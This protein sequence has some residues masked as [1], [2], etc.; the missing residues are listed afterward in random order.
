[1][2][3]TNSDIQILRLNKELRKI[4]SKTIPE[5][6][7]RT[8]NNMAF[9]SRKLSIK[10]F[11]KDHII[12]T[13][14]TQRGMLYES[15]TRGPIATMESRQGNIRPYAEQLE[16]GG[17]IEPN[18]EYI[19]VPTLAAR[20]SKSKQK[21]IAKR[22]KLPQLQNLQRMSNISGSPQRRFAAM[23]NYAR[24][25]GYYGPFITSQDDTGGARLPVGIFN[26]PGPGRKNRGGGKLMMIR[27]FESKV[28][29]KGHPFI[30]PAGIRIGE[31]MDKIYI[32]NANTMLSKNIIIK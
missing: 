2:L 11:E 30:V 19:A 12:R 5:V 4:G 22:F 6:V 20:I 24:K 14:W 3:T 9:E 21:R 28:E 7:F 29:I 32:Q 18:K 15:A 31:K 17:T 16:S 25:H 23:L 10:S 1:M 8:L 13:N 27:K 26:L